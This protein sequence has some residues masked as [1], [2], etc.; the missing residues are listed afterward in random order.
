MAKILIVEDD[1]QIMELLVMNLQVA[2]YETA[3]AQDGFQAMKVIETEPFDLAI[4]DIMIPGPDGY[5][6]LP[7]MQQRQIPVIYLS[8]K[9]GIYDRVKGLKMGAEDYLVKP[10]DILELLVRIEKVLSRFGR[11]E[12]EFTIAGVAINER[13]HTAKRDG[14]EISLKPLEF[15]LMLMF[16]K[17][18]NMVL[19]REQLLREVWG[20]TYFGETRTVDIHVAELRRKLG[21]KQSIR[22]VHRIGYK[23]EVTV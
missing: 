14:R 20:D 15:N 19:S 4:L 6:L 9:T 8:A 22:T 18:P 16:A 17:H 5:E 23:L 7:Y 2:G 12:Q 13:N 10:F 1:C 21:W 11:A 3:A